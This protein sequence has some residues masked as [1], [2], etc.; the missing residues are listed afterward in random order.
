MYILQVDFPFDGPFA[1]EMA[2]ALRPLAEDIAG[3]EQLRWKIWTED[4]DGRQAGGIYLFDDRAAAQAYLD[5]HSQRLQ[6]A[7]IRNI[8]SRIFAVNQALSLI[9]RAPI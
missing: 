1:E 8:R 4:A 3:E 9:D 2:Q 6:A 7:G 5:K